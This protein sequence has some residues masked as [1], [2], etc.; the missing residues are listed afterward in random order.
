MLGGFSQ[1]KKKRSDA[2]G[3]DERSASSSSTRRRSDH[4]GRAAQLDIRVAWPWVWPW[5]AA[6]RNETPDAAS[7][8][9]GS[10]QLSQSPYLN[11]ISKSLCLGCSQ[12]WRQLGTRQRTLAWLW[13]KSASARLGRAV[14]A[15]GLGAGKTGLGSRPSHHTRPSLLAVPAGPP[16]RQAKERRGD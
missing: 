13:L 9:S 7:S 8:G 16:V 4:R 1:A 6:A 2:D 11:L 14:L 12:G 10:G 5:A 3:R 15:L